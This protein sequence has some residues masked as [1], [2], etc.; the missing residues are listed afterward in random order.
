MV[1]LFAGGGIF[2]F[3]SFEAFAMDVPLSGIPLT[4]DFAATTVTLNSRST[5]LPK[6]S[7]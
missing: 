6:A 4:V 5:S 3:R 2:D 7:A 1:N